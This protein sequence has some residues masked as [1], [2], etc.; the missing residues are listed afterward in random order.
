[1]DDLLLVVIF[2]GSILSSGLNLIMHNPRCLSSGGNGKMD[3]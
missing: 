1:M 3:I 2:W